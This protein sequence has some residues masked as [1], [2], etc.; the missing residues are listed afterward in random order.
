[1][2]R[3]ERLCEGA[4]CST[5]QYNIQRVR[6]AF[7]GTVLTMQRIRAPRSCALGAR[8]PPLSA[9]TGIRLRVAAS[10]SARLLRLPQPMPATQQ[11]R[12]DASAV[13]VRQ[14]DVPAWIG[15]TVHCKGPSAFRAVGCKGAGGAVS[16]HMHAL[17]QRKKT[18]ASLLPFRKSRARGAGGA[19]S[20]GA[21]RQVAALASRP[22]PAPPV[23]DQ[24]PRPTQYCVPRQY[25]P[26]ETMP[27]LRWSMPSVSHIVRRMLNAR[28]CAAWCQ[29]LHAVCLRVVRLRR[30]CIFATVRLCS[31]AAHRG[32]FCGTTYTAR[33]SVP[34]PAA[35]SCTSRASA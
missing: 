30:C 9:Q 35:S 31:V 32:H 8:A 3:G 7:H 1:V 6:Q 20:C 29:L 24:P 18:S 26:F 15:R 2:T 25:P 4:T 16:N 17:I 13:R 21:S 34:L 10:G 19:V 5:Q 11:R 22:T 28:D 23:G 27:W 14:S 33:G 12:R